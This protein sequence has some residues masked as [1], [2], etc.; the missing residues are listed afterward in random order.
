MFSTCFHQDAHDN[1]VCAV[2]F[3]ADG[4]YLASGGADKNIKVWSWRSAQGRSAY[5]VFMNEC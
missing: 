4:H 1:E 5:I 3:S 2:A